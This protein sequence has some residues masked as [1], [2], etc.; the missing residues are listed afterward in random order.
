ML[1]LAKKQEIFGI[2]KENMFFVESKAETDEKLLNAGLKKETIFDE[3]RNIHQIY[4][5]K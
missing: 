3:M 4:S 2:W 5:V 1:S